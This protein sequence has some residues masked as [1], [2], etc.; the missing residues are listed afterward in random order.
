LEPFLCL[1]LERLRGEVSPVSSQAD[2][3]V[4]LV[5]A[6]RDDALRCVDEAAASV[7][8][9]TAIVNRCDEA[10]ARLADAPEPLAIVVKMDAE[11]ASQVFAHVRGQ[12]HLAH[13]PIFGV[14]PERTDLAFTELFSWGGDDLLALK[15][16]PALARRLRPLVARPPGRR[17]SKPR[18][19]CAL[20]AGADALWRS[21]MGR[22]LYQGGFSVRFV[23]SAG[24]LAQE[25]LAEGV[26]VVVLADDL[27]AGEGAGAL[28]AARASGSQAAW[29][30]AAPPKRM[31]PLQ[32]E[33][34]AFGPVSVADGFAPP[35][36]V[37]F[38][39]NELLSRR[40]VDQ[41]A[42][43]RVLYGSTVAFRAAGRDEDEIGFSYNVNAGGVYV[44]TLAPLDA[45]QELWLEMWPP[46]SERRVRLAGTVA[47]R[48][49]FGPAEGATVPA[50]FGVKITEGL[51]GDLDRWR[52]G[53][54]AFAKSM[55]G[56]RPPAPPSRES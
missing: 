28:K 44:R 4:V 15:S 12:G 42:T 50:G 51:A 8:L 53:Y 7:G 1:T 49:S 19:H 34:G 46:R 25:S 20:V 10:P 14:A 52:V 48:R 16:P 36:N 47:W 5:G 9:A 17:E 55:L 21:V 13:L 30:F 26:C 2:R 41:R 38:L 39:T 27:G 56:T 23:A 29:I 11:G 54:E 22:A 37:L 18:E 43:A 31:A 33:V 32:A 3:S 40:G 45:G 35:E 24:N 6:F